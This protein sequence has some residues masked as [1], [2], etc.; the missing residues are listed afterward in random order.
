MPL[1]ACFPAKDLETF[2]NFKP[3]S[4]PPYTINSLLLYYLLIKFAIMRDS[5]HFSHFCRILPNETNG[6][7]A[8][9]SHFLPTLYFE[10]V[11]KNNFPLC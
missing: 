2:S 1:T 8:F 5:S 7:G 11:L 4:N 9:L 6:D 10:F 3:I